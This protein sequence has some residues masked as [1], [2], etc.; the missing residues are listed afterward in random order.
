M[1]GSSPYPST[2]LLKDIHNAPGN[3]FISGGGGTPTKNIPMGDIIAIRGY[4]K[5]HGCEVCGALFDLLGTGTEGWYKAGKMDY[6]RTSKRLE[7][8]H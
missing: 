5:S 3:L 7:K 6:Q 2:S 4:N 1:G 8:N